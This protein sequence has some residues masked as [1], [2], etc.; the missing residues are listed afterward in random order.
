M[1]YLKSVNNVSLK[2]SLGF[3]I[4]NPDIY[5]LRC[6]LSQIVHRETLVQ[7][8]IF[9]YKFHHRMKKQSFLF[10]YFSLNESTRRK[11]DFLHLM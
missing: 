8:A 10:I 1:R 5:E 6:Y 4:F 7:T 3:A 9:Y 11:K 2:V